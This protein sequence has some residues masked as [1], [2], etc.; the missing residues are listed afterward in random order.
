MF[1]DFVEDG[2]TPAGSGLPQVSS[3]VIVHIPNDDTAV[4]A[5]QLRVSVDGQVLEDSLRIDGEWHRVNWDE[6][7]GIWRG[8]MAYVIKPFALETLLRL[9]D[10]GTEIDACLIEAAMKEPETVI[11]SRSLW[12]T[13]EHLSE[14]LKAR[15]RREAEPSAL[16]TWLRGFLDG[17][18]SCTAKELLER[19]ID[20]HEE[21]R[22]QGPPLQRVL[23]DLPPGTEAA[24]DWDALEQEGPSQRLGWRRLTQFVAALVALTDDVVVISVDTGQ[25]DSDVYVQLCREDDGALTLEAVSDAFME[26]PL[27]PDA[28]DVLREMG[29]EDPPG[30]GLPNFVQYLESDRTAPAEVA[31][32]LVETLRRAYSVKPSDSFRFAPLAHV[33]GLLKGDFGPDLAANPDLRASRRARLPL[34]MSF[35]RDVGPSVDSLDESASA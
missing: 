17:E 25:Y 7:E 35:P 27:P 32:I 29:W 2:G 21:A 18:H 13:R 26:P 12:F 15:G 22:N 10:A 8:S 6:Q 34:G 5:L 20:L 19:L 9:H 16:T 23:T 28:I 30:E 33:R 1:E 14:F 4:S 31:G 11:S 24:L 3:D